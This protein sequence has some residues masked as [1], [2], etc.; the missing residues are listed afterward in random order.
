MDTNRLRQFCAIVEAGTLTQASQ[1]LHIT[2]SALSKS[3]KLL[4]QELN[5]VL[6]R[7]AGRGL[8]VTSTGW[9]MYE[10]TKVF[11]KQE[12]SLF[13]LE[14]IAKQT[15]LRI[16]TVEIFLM[17][18]RDLL[19]DKLF[20][21]QAVTFLDLNPGNIEQRIV[22]GQ[23]DYGLTYAPFPM[24]ELEIVDIGRYRLGCYYLKNAFKDELITEIPFVVP[25]QGL[26]DNPLGIKERDGWLDSIFPREKKYTVNLLSTGIEL[27]LQGLCAIYIP[28]FVAKKINH[29]RK[30][31]EQ[32][33]RHSLPKN[34][35]KPQSAFLI[36]HKENADV[37]T[38]K[39]LC[40]IMKKLFI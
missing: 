17:A 34:Q 12:E 19:T 15:T 7:P 29:T 3:M 35:Q 10:R 25:N 4:Q 23:L 33:I 26:S 8:M 14:P 39:R 13:K 30:A 24:K 27:T 36:R 16:G 18:M 40:L 38:F 37:V 20:T 32:L 11:L 22:D 31:N 28:D 2:H 21:T 9:L 6:F 1:L 5:C